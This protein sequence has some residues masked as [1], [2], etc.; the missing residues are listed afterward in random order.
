ML[1]WLFA[2]PSIPNDVGGKYVAGAYIVFVA[3][4]VIYVGIM[5]RRLSRTEK[6][7]EQLKQ[8]VR[9]REH[10]EASNPPDHDVETIAAGGLTRAPAVASPDGER[11]CA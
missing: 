2:A 6:D 8:D 10:A 7:L 1:A 11:R 9:A 5:A 3:L 4:I